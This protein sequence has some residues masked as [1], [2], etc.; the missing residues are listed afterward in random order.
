MEA[1]TKAWESVDWERLQ[2]RVE[3]EISALG[4]RQDDSDARKER[5][6]EQSNAYKDRTNKENRKLA[7][8]LIKAFQNEFEGLLARSSAAESA[9]IDICGS[10][11]NLPDPK[12][13][14][15]SAEAWKNDAEKT[16]KAVEEREDL[17]RQ[18]LKVN[19][20]LEDFKGKDVKVRKLKDKLAKLESEQDTF[21]ENAVSEVEKKAELELN[22]RLADL[23]AEKEKMTEQND[24]L[25]KSLDSLETKNKDI[26]RKLEI[27]KMSVEQKEGLE[28]EQLA[29]TMKDLSDANHKIIFLEERIAQ[30]ESEAE[31][32]NE[33]K[34]AGNI[35]DIAAL[36]SVLIQKDEVIQQL[37][38]DMK[39]AETSHAEDVAKWKTAL[40]ALEK[41]TKDW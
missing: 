12:T 23:I 14:L 18:L 17:K 19:N 35:E 40:S 9:L 7:I 15:K 1:V 27:A 32:V 20:E 6:V 31:K 16:Q 21:I 41:K 38:N 10:I 28:N 30:L 34:K 2:A 22:S 13:L 29:I 24:I 26:Q 36:G 39:K 25:E 37:T 4:E 3:A 5:L 11:T 33:S 8:P